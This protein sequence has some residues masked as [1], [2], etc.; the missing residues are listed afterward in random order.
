MKGNR[1]KSWFGLIYIMVC[2][3][4]FTQI[5]PIS[6]AQAN[7]YQNGQSCAID[8]GTD[9]LFV[10]Q[11]TPDMKKLDISSNPNSKETYISEAINYLKSFNENKQNDRAGVIGFN[12][13]AIKH[14]ELT[15]NFFTVEKA[16]K[17]LETTTS[18]TKG[19]NDLSTAIE[20]ALAEIKKNPSANQKDI[21]VLTTGTS[22]NNQKSLQLAR[23]AYEEGITIH[24]MA[25]GATTG[26]DSTRLT[27]IA[28]QT[29]GNYYHITN[30]SA[31]K[32][33]LS[34]LKYGVT[35]FKGRTISSDWK[36]TNDVVE[37]DGLLIEDNVK[38]DLNGYSLTVQGEIHMQPCSEL[39]AADYGVI[40]ATTINQRSGALISL[41]NSQLRV[42]KTFTQDGVVR[43]NG[44]YKT[45]QAEMVINSYNQRIRGM[46]DLNKQQLTVATNFMQEGTVH[47]GGGTASIK[48]SLT[49]QGRFNV[50]AGE[51]FVGGNLF[52]Q[53]GP[54]VDD[55]FEENRSLDVG[56]GLV[57]VGSASSMN[58]TREIGNIRQTDGQLYVNHGT[59][60]VY[61]D[62]TVSG[63]WLTMIK[64]SMD[65]SATDYSE[66][67]GDYVHVHRDFTM[68]SARNHAE[69]FYT[70]MTKPSNDQAHLTDGV[71]RVDGKFSQ[72]G[73]RLF[74][75]KASDRSYGY[76]NDYSRNNFQASGRHK[77][78]LT[79]KQSISAEGL[80]FT[81]QRLQLN[82]LLTD[83]Q[84][85]S[86]VKW[87]E[88]IEKEES[89]SS[90]AT[91]RNLSINGI[92]VVGFN[93]NKANYPKHSVPST[94]SPTVS[95]F[96][97]ANDQ[98]AKV[99]VLN[100]AIVNNQANVMIIVTAADGKT[101][102]TYTVNV[103]IGGGDDGRV[104]SI[105]F[106]QKHFSFVQESGASFKP[107]N[108]TVKYR[109]N[110][111]NAHNHQVVWR[112]TNE[113]VATV[114]NGIITPKGLGEATIIATTADGGFTD[115][116]TV[117]VLAEHSLTQGIKTLADLVS[118]E[119]RYNKVMAL[120][121]GLD[122]I[123]IIVPGKYVK[124]LEFAT[125]GILTAGKVTVD[126]SVS[127]IGVKVSGIEMPVV[128][129]PANSTYTFSRYGLTANDYI[130]VIAYN[131]AGDELERIFT[132]YPVEYTPNSIIQP[133]YHSLADLLGN[134]ILFDMILEQYALDELRVEFH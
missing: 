20:L 101:K 124:K 7:T 130:E 24:I 109:I 71:L 106:D 70:H 97:Q 118:D 83:Y 50:E 31:M 36:L 35:N 4:V 80:G 16:L 111:N 82:G 15:D 46:L 115:A 1:K 99:E 28:E 120:Y 134:P 44:P 122:D 76:T 40:T 6:T 59:V 48:G 42:D 37:P 49:Q 53:G 81:F 17:S 77:V 21:I 123:G 62:Y 57:E 133:G 112:S 73:N 27:Q 79:G 61:G 39:R 38:V 8:R 98:N 41:N 3:L 45:G 116:A 107:N 13:D 58:Q 104:T 11:D 9:T 26:I 93:P 100:T 29:G 64:G 63:G 12:I 95:V 91:L 43:V 113:N 19:G 10:I 88:L 47:L 18:H 75:E 60:R 127:K 54:L 25:M 125:S 90:D 30:A 105:V 14:A 128:A 74:H 117:E 110:P 5:A 131:H 108:A 67:D 119:E 55:E 87:K 102:M 96:T 78:V 23:E 51:L 2:L 34:G 65:T 92:S 132:H 114:Q 121:G 68:A 86:A 129:S 89:A 69:R 72:I 33:H 103:Q 22:I 85:N 126:S 84:Y 94:T 32:N 56:G 66:A 52:I